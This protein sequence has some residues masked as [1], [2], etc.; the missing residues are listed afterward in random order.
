MKYCIYCGNQLSDEARFCSKCGK[1]VSSTSSTSTTSSNSRLIWDSETGT[2]KANPDFRPPVQQNNPQ[3][4]YRSSYSNAS[5]HGGTIGFV[6]TFFLGLIGLI[7]CLCLGDEYCK[8]AAKKTF[9]VLLIIGLILG[10]IIGGIASC[11]IDDD[12][13]DYYYVFKNILI[14]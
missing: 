10:I 5:L 14:K 1:S 2:Y 6:L 13:D 12:Y 3:N 11:A 4:Y 8:S 9:V 7:L